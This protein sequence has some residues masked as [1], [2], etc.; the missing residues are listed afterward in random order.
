MIITN[1]AIYNLKK[2]ELKRRID[3]SFVGGITVSS[4]IDEFVVHC[5]DIEYDYY[6]VSNR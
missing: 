4:L 6:F 3:I 1:R 2:K 5:N